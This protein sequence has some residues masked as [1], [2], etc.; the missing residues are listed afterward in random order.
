MSLL[1]LAQYA[2]QQ[3]QDSASKLLG[4]SQAA[5]SKAIKAGRSIYV[6]HSDAGLAVAIELKP[7]P[8][9]SSKDDVS[10]EEILTGIA[11]HSNTLDDA[12][13]SSSASLAR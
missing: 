10:M 8:G 9:K 1:T 13:Q 5:V 12:V 4:L 2:A 11:R 6:F 3:S 7:F